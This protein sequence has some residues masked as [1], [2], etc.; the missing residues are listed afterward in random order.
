M[1]FWSFDIRPV[2][3]EIARIACRETGVVLVALDPTE[4]AAFA[5]TLPEP[6]H[7]AV[8]AGA[9]DSPWLRDHSPLAFE[10]DAGRGAL[11]PRRPE[12]ARQR[13][14]ELFAR[15]LAAPPALTGTRIARGNLVAGPKG[16]AVS[17]FDLIRENPG[18]GDEAFRRDAAAA[19]IVDWLL[20]PSFPDDRSRHADTMLRFLRP[21]LAA[22]ARRPGHREADRAS[23]EA[24]AALARL[25]PGIEIVEIPALDDGAG[26]NSPL[27][28]IQ[29]GD[30]LMVPDY[31]GLAANAEAVEH[32]LSGR[33]LRV[34]PVRCPT[35]GL[36]GGLHCLTASIFG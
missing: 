5:E 25:R 32:A 36:G 14:A 15:I 9:F 35:R 22:V 31:E 1:P 27:N 10:H 26:W 3:E 2:L 7:V 33:A 19:G 24:A 16:I 12:G 20:I 13:D 30:L 11:R 28:W 21:D 18:K 23:A 34:I 4:A 17:T 29:L 6:D 8:V